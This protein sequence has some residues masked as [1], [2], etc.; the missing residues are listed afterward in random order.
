[1]NTPVY[2]SSIC[3]EN[4]CGAFFFI[5]ICSPEASRVMSA[6]V[7]LTRA[8]K[9]RS[10]EVRRT[11]TLF[12]ASEWCVR[13]MSAPVEFGFCVWAYGLCMMQN[14]SFR[15][16]MMIA[17]GGVKHVKLPEMPPS[18]PWQLLTADHCYRFQWWLA[19]SG[20]V[21][22]SW[23]VIFGVI[24]KGGLSQITQKF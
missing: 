24:S 20:V 14:V 23:L 1:M 17:C 2:T 12:T 7:H 19:I 22:V 5:S 6:C 15:C 13:D 9:R 4:T 11:V 16:R 21:G 18:P 3:R 8:C 10:R